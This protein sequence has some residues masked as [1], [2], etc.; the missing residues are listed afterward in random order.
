MDKKIIATTYPPENIDKRLEFVWLQTSGT[1][2]SDP[3]YRTLTP[4]EYF[5]SINHCNQGNIRE[6]RWVR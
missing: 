6:F 4:E 3:P 1:G 5:N 2:R